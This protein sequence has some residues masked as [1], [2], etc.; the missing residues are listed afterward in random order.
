[1]SIELNHTIVHSRDAAAAARFL[2][3]ILGVEPRPKWGPFH[4]VVVDH[5]LALDYVDDPGSFTAQHYAFL[6]SDDVFD[7]AHQRL[8][9]GGIPMWADPHQHRPGQINHIDGGRGVYFEDPDGHMME[10]LTVPYGGWPD[11]GGP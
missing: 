11:P 9:D 8:L 7:A 2:A 10:L 4:P 3:E 5:G 6:V 1:M